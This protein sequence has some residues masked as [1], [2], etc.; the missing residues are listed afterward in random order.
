MNA[1]SVVV[2]FYDGDEADLAQ[3]ITAGVAAS[4]LPTVVAQSAAT[5][6]SSEGEAIV[7]AIVIDR[8][9]SLEKKKL[10]VVEG[11]RLFRTAV[12]KSTERR[13]MQLAVLFFN[14]GVAEWNPFG[15]P[16]PFMSMV[17]GHARCMPELAEAAYKPSGS[18]A[19]YKAY[20]QAVASCDLMAKSVEESLG[21]DVRQ[22]IIGVGDGFDNNSTKD[23]LM[24]LRSIIKRRRLQ[25]NWTGMFFGICDP[26]M[27][28]AVATLVGRSW[29]GMAADEQK[30]FELEVFRAVGC[31]TE[32]KRLAKAINAIAHGNT[33]AN[34]GQ[35]GNDDV[36]MGLSENLVETFPSDGD[37]IRDMIGVKMSS[38][39]I[40]ASQGKITANVP[41]AQ[42]MA[43][44]DPAG[45]GSFV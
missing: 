11:V 23:D 21:V 8:S 30:A 22:V 44:P 10:A 4:A 36:G 5:A 42:Q 40:R 32:D 34:M 7:G 38:T 35:F 31:G 28:E 25:E 26:E 27:L 43:T 15:T 6:Q 3:A 16:D 13:K 45:S 33:H 29:H 24:H 17:E 9:G 14:H 39:F 37:E 18:T 12:M 41:L 19:L 1:H 20:L 2:P